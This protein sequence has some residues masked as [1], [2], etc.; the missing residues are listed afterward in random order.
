[1][2][3]D[4]DRDRAVDRLLRQSLQGLGSET[5]SEACLNAETLA[6]WADGALAG[7]A[8]AAAAAHAADCSRCLAM[9]SAVVRTTPP[10]AAIA[11]WWTRLGA[12][13]W[14]VPLTATAAA[15]VIWVAGSR[16]PTPPQGAAMPSGRD[17]VSAVVPQQPGAAPVGQMP[18]EDAAREARATAPVPAE[19]G[20]SK[21]EPLSVAKAER[22]DASVEANEAEAPRALGRAAQPAAAAP[23]ESDTLGARALASDDRAGLA[24]ASAGATVR[25]RLAAGGFV[26]RSTTGGASWDRMP[27]GTEAVLTALAAPSDSVCWTVGPGGVVLVTTNARDWQRLPFPVPVDLAAVRAT[28]AR[29][30]IV[31]AADGRVFATEDGGF[32]WMPRPLQEF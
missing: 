22:Q 7:E 27:T 31:T 15:V 23:A 14:L 29:R 1:M 25:W 4:A 17:E 19:L 8:A 5:A 3:H 21:A 9:L 28:D 32:T 26:E 12:A 11:P 2:T 10:P 20:E 30:A 13:R 6:A 18:Q 16:T 24:A